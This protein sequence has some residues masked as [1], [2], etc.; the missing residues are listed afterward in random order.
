MLPSCWSSP[1]CTTQ[2]S[3]NFP[4][5]SLLYSTWLP[6]WSQGEN[7]VETTRCDG[8][9]FSQ[10]FNDYIKS[11]KLLLWYF[12]YRRI[13]S[14]LSRRD[15]EYMLSHVSQFALLFCVALRALDILSDEV[16]MELSAAYRRMV[17][18]PQALGTSQVTPSQVVKF[19]CLLPFF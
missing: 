17:S 4:V 8:S 2:S 12:V 11:N 19:L 5:S 16:L 14:H 1:P 7:Y 18:H 10:Q 6:C 13:T 15:T 9:S 3:W